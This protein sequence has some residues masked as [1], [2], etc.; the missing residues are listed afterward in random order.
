MKTFVLMLALLAPD[1]TK[2]EMPVELWQF[3]SMAQC[4]KS[5]AMMNSGKSVNRFSCVE[6]APGMK[7]A[8]EH[9]SKTVIR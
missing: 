1:G 7:V 3:Q 6:F 9:K 8:A 5:A 2:G 4:D